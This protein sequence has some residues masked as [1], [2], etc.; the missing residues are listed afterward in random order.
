MKLNST[1]RYWHLTRAF[2]NGGAETSI[3]NFINESFY[4]TFINKIK[5]E[6]TTAVCNELNEIKKLKV[7]NSDRRGNK[8]VNGYTC[9]T[10][11]PLVILR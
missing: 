5:D 2:Q 11:I 8:C 1:I 6:V 4:T 10:E 9:N 7:V 3:E